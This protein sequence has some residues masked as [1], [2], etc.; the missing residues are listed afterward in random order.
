MCS[1]S[2]TYWSHLL[3]QESRCSSFIGCRRDGGLSGSGSTLHDNILT[4]GIQSFVA[5]QT[6]TKEVSG[7]C[8][9]RYGKW[10]KSRIFHEI[11]LVVFNRPWKNVDRSSGN[12]P[13][14]C[15]QL[16][17]MPDERLDSCRA[18][19]NLHFFS[20]I[21]IVDDGYLCNIFTGEKVKS[22]EMWGKDSFTVWRR[23]QFIQCYFECEKETWINLKHPVYYGH[24]VFHPLDYVT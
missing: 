16:N 12:I 13:Y 11:L 19:K 10:W 17:T 1:F 20:H 3:W 4:H 6:R 21:K 2:F 18:C 5:W 14:V 7:N 15:L 22:S 24:R 8:I 23:T 9:L